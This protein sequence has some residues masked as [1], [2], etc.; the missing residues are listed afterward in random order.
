VPRREWRLRIEDMLSSIGKIER[1]TEGMTFEEFQQDDKTVDAVIRNFQIIGEAARH[2]PEEIVTGYPVLPWAPMR[3][4]RNIVIHEYGSV[5][6]ATIWNTLQ[7]D[8]PPLVPHLRRI[9]DENP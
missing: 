1:Y 8:L 9:L 5:R 2:V 6:L 7:H 4:M 3:G